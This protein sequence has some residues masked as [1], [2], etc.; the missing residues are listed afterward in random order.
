M[1]ETPFVSIPDTVSLSCVVSEHTQ[2]NIKG[3]LTRLRWRQDKEKVVATLH[4]QVGVRGREGRAP[5]VEVW[6]V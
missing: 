6:R 2:A 4:E 1:R 5:K 3:W